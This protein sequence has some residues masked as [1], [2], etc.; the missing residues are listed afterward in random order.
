[1]EEL[2]RIKDGIIVSKV[3]CIPDFINSTV[4]IFYLL[5][6]LQEYNLFSIALSTASVLPVTASL[7]LAIEFNYC[8]AAVEDKLEVNTKLSIP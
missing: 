8:I 6:G 7:L 4:V 1:M 5:Y 3:L 2:N